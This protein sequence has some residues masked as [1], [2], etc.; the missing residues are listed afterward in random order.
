MLSGVVRRATDAD[1]DDLVA[2]FT[3]GFAEDPVFN[4]IYETK[5][6]YF[7][8]APEFFRWLTHVALEVGTAYV[9]EGKGG[10]LLRPSS[11]VEA[12]AEYERDVE[13]LRA[14][15][16][17]CANNLVTFTAEQRKN[18]P[19]ESAHSYGLLQAVRSEYRSEAIGV[20]LFMAWR[21]ESEDS[22]LPMY[23]EASSPRSLAFWTRV[24]FK[25]MGEFSLGEGVPLT[26]IWRDVP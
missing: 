1:V 18:H 25:S 26:P 22:G 7:R 4:W 24:G 14:I 13:R 5:D 12:D 16:G 17:E 20:A 8:L 23:T 3:E 11:T 6:Q 19:M 9:V 10:L 21:R 15:G 2:S